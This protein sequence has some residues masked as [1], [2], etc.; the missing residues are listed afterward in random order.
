LINVAEVMVTAPGLE[1]SDSSTLTPDMR[2]Y[3]RDV[4]ERLTRQ[5]MK[6]VTKAR[7]GFPAAE[8]VEYAADVG[9]GLIAMTTHGRSGLRRVI[10]GSV[11]EQI[12]RTAPCAVLVRPLARKAEAGEPGSASR[13]PA[14]A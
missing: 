12:F 13:I 14:T 1:Y 9:A 7:I 5:G 8:I 11:A 2:P 10:M 6:V 4:R 3:L